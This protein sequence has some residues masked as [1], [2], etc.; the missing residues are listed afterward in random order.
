MRDCSA[1]LY[2]HT[3]ADVIELSRLAYEKM[4]ADKNSALDELRRKVEEE[5]QHLQDMKTSD[6]NAQKDMEMSR[7]QI[8][9]LSAGIAA[10]KE[11]LAKIQAYLKDSEERIAK[12]NHTL[13]I[14]GTKREQL[15][16]E[17]TVRASN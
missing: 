6:E 17:L 2:T 8:E 9:T 14:L 3:H 13:S 16:Q 7:Y 15:Q 5:A 4:L 10:A 1:A 12:E 11:S